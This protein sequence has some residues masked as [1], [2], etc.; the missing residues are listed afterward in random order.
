DVQVLYEDEFEEH[1]E[2]V[3]EVEEMDDE[4]EGSFVGQTDTFKVDDDFAFEE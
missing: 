4:W 2:D 3:L 1:G